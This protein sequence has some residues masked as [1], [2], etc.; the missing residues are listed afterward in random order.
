M[1]SEIDELLKQVNA[2]PASPNDLNE[3]KA[4]LERLIYNTIAIEGN[5]MSLTSVR[6]VLRTGA[7]IEGHTEQEHF[8][9]KGLA[10]ALKFI[11]EKKKQGRR[12]SVKK[13]T[14]GVCGFA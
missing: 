10:E 14:L 13:L 1:F 12:L 4:F 7:R 5:T 11:E 3:R 2:L 8:E 9:V 6:T